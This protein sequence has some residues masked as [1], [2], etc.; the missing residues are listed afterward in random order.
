VFYLTEAE[1]KVAHKLYGLP[2]DHGQVVGMGISVQRPAPSAIEEAR[3]RLGLPEHYFLY[4][5]RVDTAKGCGRLVEAF[6]EFSP[7]APDMALVLMGQRFMPVPESRQVFCTGFVSEADRDAVMAGAMALVMPSRYE[8]LSMVL[9][10][11]MRLGVPVLANQE[12]E[13]LADHIAHSGGGLHYA[14]HRDLVAKMRKLV[15][16]APQERDA[17]GAAGKDYVEARYT[18]PRVVER[19]C[20]A[21]SQL[22]A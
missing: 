20:T 22:P 5:G 16:A 11:A 1:R 6:N 8:S 9:L 2:V 17:M 4:V 21:L 19:Y 13:V 7:S 10:E 18:W 15:R 12:C 3:Q 14:G